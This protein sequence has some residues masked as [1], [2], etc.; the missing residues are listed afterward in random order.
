MFYE[1]VCLFVL[2]FSTKVAFIITFLFY[3][4]HL[5]VLP[6]KLHLQCISLLRCQDKQKKKALNFLGRRNSST[7]F[8]D[9]CFFM[10]C[11]HVSC[12]E[13]ESTEAGCSFICTTSDTTYF[14]IAFSY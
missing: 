13:V 5:D 2:A 7:V 1:L 6:N 8:W 9:L 14:N 12:L 3:L 11:L 4:A 10:F